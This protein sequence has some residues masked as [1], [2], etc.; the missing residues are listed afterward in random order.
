MSRCPDYTRL[1]EPFVIEKTDEVTVP[2][3]K[4]RLA[5]SLVGDV[6]ECKIRPDGE[7]AVMKSPK[8]HLMMYWSNGPDGSSNQRWWKQECKKSGGFLLFSD[9]FPSR[10]L[11]VY[12]A[13]GD[14]PR[15]NLG[16]FRKRG[17]GHQ[18][19]W[20]L[21]GKGRL[22]SKAN[23]KLCI[24][25]VGRHC[26]TGSQ[27]KLASIH[28]AARKQERWGLKDVSGGAVLIQS[29]FEDYVIDVAGGTDIRELYYLARWRKEPGLV[30]L[31][32]VVWNS[33]SNSAE[34]I[35]TERLGKQLGPGTGDIQEEDCV[36]R[37]IREGRARP[38]T[39]AQAAKQ[40]LPV[41]CFLRRVHLDGYAH[42]DL[43]DGNVLKGG[44]ADSAPFSVIDL[45]S[46]F[47]A[48][49]F[50]EDLG[51]SC[52]AAWCVTRDWRAFA[53]HFIS[54]IDGRSRRLW[55]L[56]GQNDELPKKRT[57]WEVK[58]KVSVA[59]SVANGSDGQKWII[60]EKKGS[61]VNR[62][63]GYVLDLSGEDD[64]TVLAF[65]KHGGEN[66][67]WR[68]T[69]SYIECHAGGKRLELRGDGS[70]VVAAAA[71]SSER[72]VW[73][74]DEVSQEIVNPATRRVLDMFGDVRLPQ[75]VK[76]LVE[77]LGSA[78][79]PVFLELLDALFKAR[80]DPSEICTLLGLLASRAGCSA[81]P[82]AREGGA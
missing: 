35:I 27:L 63:S 66:Q 59:A 67:R 23:E 79:D 39:P 32:H 68:I 25:V 14:N 12:G 4:K 56:V 28:E 54:L 55:D 44:K 13:A 64:S 18:Q 73:R 1:L 7:D 60:D 43:H 36:L 74:Y 58:Q 17:S 62:S 9:E 21:D 16:E 51:D 57:D 45:G 46:V 33:S 65:P 34:F 70:Y 52:G 47:E 6:Y 77:M 29:A 10:V 30:Q 71:T 15:L 75:D 26:E 2:G 81:H 80:A 24:A 3:S 48:G 22:V 37:D 78:A 20:T 5:S 41:A 42:N 38:R 40:L 76:K 72:Q 8:V 53:I 11:E 61:I 19:R 31:R 49:H 50:M 69:D 82:G